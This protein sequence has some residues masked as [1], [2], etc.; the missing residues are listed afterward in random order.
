MSPR[1]LAACGTIAFVRLLQFA[2]APQIFTPGRMYDGRKNI[3][4][5]PPQ[6]VTQDNTVSTAIMAFN[7]VIRMRPSLWRLHRYRHGLQ[8][9]GPLLSLCLE[10]IKKDN[11]NALSP[12]DGLPDRGRLQAQDPSSPQESELCNQNKPLQFPDVICTEVGS[13]ALI[14]LEL[15]DVPPGE[16]MRKPVPP[17]K[18]RRRK[19]FI[20]TELCDKAII[21]LVF[22]SAPEASYQEN[23]WIVFTGSS[24]DHLERASSASEVFS[25]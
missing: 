23:L 20:Q 13:G 11:P 15:Y 12:T 17:E 1:K 5:S 21:P 14:P 22:I 19:T 7:I 3:K 6:G 8:D 16:L 24:S 18:T 4:L 2:V 9:F 25:L 10:F